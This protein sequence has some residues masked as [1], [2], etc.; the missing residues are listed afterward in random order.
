MVCILKEMRV[1]SISL[2]RS[3]FQTLSTQLRNTGIGVWFNRVDERNRQQLYQRHAKLD[4]IELMVQLRLLS[5]FQLQALRSR[6]ASW[7]SEVTA[8][9][10]R[11][12]G[13]TKFVRGRQS[14]AGLG[15]VLPLQILM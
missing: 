3:I 12:G 2:Q 8:T 7:A 10:E 15:R 1:V 6:S 5:L 4:F 9:M 11:R 14:E 13:G